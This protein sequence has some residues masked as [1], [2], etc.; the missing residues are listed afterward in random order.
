M[1]A[2]LRKRGQP[3]H[4]RHGEVEQHDVGLERGRLGDRA[5]AV[6]GLTDDVEALLH[7]QR[8]Q[9][10]SCQRVVVDDE[11]TLRH[12]TLIGRSRRADK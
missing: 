3:V 7:E 9:R 11:H 1:L 10:V 12:G 5:R 8:R 6:L 2:N 4:A